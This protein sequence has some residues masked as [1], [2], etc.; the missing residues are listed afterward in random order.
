MARIVGESGAW[1]TFVDELRGYGLAIVRPTDIEPL[2]NQLRAGYQ[3]SVDRRRDETAERLREGENKIGRL[4]AERGLFRVLINWFKIREAKAIIPLLRV[5]EQRY[6]EALRRNIERLEELPNT[7]GMAG[8]EAELQVIERLKSLRYDH[9]VFN[10][11]HLQADRFIR[12]EGHPL[13]S[14][15]LDHVV[16]SPAGIFVIETKRWS[17]DF[18]ASGG[19]HDPF[20]QV[21][22][23]SYLCYALLKERFGK[24]RVR[25][26]IAFQGHLPS[27]PSNSYVKV[28][29][30]DRLADYISRFK[31]REIEDAE[32]RAVREF[33]ER[34]VSPS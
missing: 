7:P 18:A 4:R 25:S 13:Q 24:L 30:V 5:K 28:L 26:I 19:F 12:F 1:K 17:R 21:Q 9:V 20:Q 34:H 8:A 2:L 14:A 10:D 16:L 32:L 33:F 27:Q 23:A 3:E 15:Q 11:V 22:R 29:P 31:Q 6:I